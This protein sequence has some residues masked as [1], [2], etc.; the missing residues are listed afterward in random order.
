MQADQFVEE[1]KIFIGLSVKL[2]ESFWKN[3][4]L[5]EKNN[6]PNF[7]KDDIKKIFIK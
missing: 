3:L 2:R 6:F 1:L 4:P 7:L 5:N